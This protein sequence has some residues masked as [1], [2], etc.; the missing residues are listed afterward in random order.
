MPS[1]APPT[2][3]LPVHCQVFSWFRCYF[4]CQ[5]IFFES[6]PQVN[7]AGCLSCA[8]HLFSFGSSHSAE[9]GVF[10]STE[11]GQVSRLSPNLPFSGLPASADC[12][13]HLRYKLRD[14][15]YCCY[16]NESI[17]DQLYATSLLMSSC[18]IIP[19]L[20]GGGYYYPSFIAGKLRLREI[21]YP[22]AYN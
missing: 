15:S 14:I 12:K 10:P 18:F 5:W 8:K 13:T 22:R 7:E 16:H 4:A 20:L 2:L 17:G 11:E 9:V 21:T 3:S 19:A 6:L 1:K